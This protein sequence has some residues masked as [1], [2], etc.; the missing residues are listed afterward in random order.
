MEHFTQGRVEM[1]K[2]FEELSVQIQNQATFITTMT[3]GVSFQAGETT[4]LLKAFRPVGCHWSLGS[5]WQP[6]SGSQHTGSPK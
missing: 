6:V 5:N 3:S 1:K 2:G 4:K